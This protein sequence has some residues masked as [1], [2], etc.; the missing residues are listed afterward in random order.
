MQWF[1]N[2]FVSIAVVL[3][4]LTAGFFPTQPA[5]TIQQALPTTSNAKPDYEENAIH[6]TQPYTDPDGY[7]S[8]NVPVDWKV[9]AITKGPIE[10]DVPHP[11][12]EKVED[13][14]IVS[15]DNA[16]RLDIEVKEHPVVCAFS[17]PRYNSTLAGL[18]ATNGFSGPV[19]NGFFSVP[20]MEVWTLETSEAEFS[21]SE[22]E[23]VDT[24]Y[25]G[26]TGPAATPNPTV[27]EV[28]SSSQGSPAEESYKHQ[29][30]VDADEKVAADL[31]TSSF[32]PNIVVARGAIPP[33]H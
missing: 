3:Q 22:G 30:A 12:P 28:A 32:R 16:V 31:V 11:L 15:S 2:F 9:T 14:E 26:P 8:M 24:S 20:S 6:D 5:P 19:V 21:I 17:S 18:P 10:I 1:A 4:T 23:K 13:V 7:F 29:A 33:C 27:A 25:S